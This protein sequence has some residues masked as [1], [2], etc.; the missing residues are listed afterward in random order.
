MRFCS[1]DEERMET[2]FFKNACVCLALVAAVLTWAVSS[3]RVLNVECFYVI[4][5]GRSRTSARMTGGWFMFE[6]S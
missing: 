4:R 1:D 2:F 6:C 3:R 5:V